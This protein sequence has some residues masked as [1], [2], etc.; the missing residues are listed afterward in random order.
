MR[1][2]TRWMETLRCEVDIRDFAPLYVDEPPSMGGANTA[3]NPMELVLAAL[4]A[5]QEIL[6][7]A[8]AALLD[9]PLEAVEVSLTGYM[10]VREM[11]DLQHETGAGFSKI[12]SEARLRSSASEADIRRLVETVER[13]CPVMDTLQRPVMLTN[14]VHLNDQLLTR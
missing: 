5:C 2:N 9:I 6:Y 10:D 8:Y 11:F 4:G 14:Q 13:C 1:T 7:S 12:R 3:P